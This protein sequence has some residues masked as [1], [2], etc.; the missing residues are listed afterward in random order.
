MKVSLNQL[1]L[2]EIREMSLIEIAYEILNDK[3]EP[4]SFQELFSQIVNY[5]GLSEEEAKSKISQFYTDLNVDGRFMNV[6]GNA[7][8]IKG[9]YPVEQF[10]DDIVPTTRI[11]KKKGKKDDD[12]LDLYDDE[13][14]IE[15]EDFLDE[16]DDE[17]LDLE[18]DEFLDEEDEDDLD[19]VDV[20]DDD[21]FE[22][23]DIID[24]D[25]LLD[26]EEFEEDDLDED[27]DAF[28]DEEDE[29]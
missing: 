12:D 21:E 28:I 14:L 13:D 29:E 25:L 16:Y 10:E 9:W 27:L 23:E 11:K 3:K 17:D 22:D 8:G 5:L 2:D 18:D 24:D 26:D 4:V 1:T 20:D 7:W 6:G 15:D 19:D